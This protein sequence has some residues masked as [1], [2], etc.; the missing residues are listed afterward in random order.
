MH[1]K[2][3]KKC[4]QNKAE[5]SNL[6][7]GNFQLVMYDKIHSKLEQKNI[8]KVSQNVSILLKNSSII[9]IKKSR[10]LQTS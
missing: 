6:Y 10:Y 7:I 1:S 8:S 2:L 3:E 9:Q 4:L 5:I